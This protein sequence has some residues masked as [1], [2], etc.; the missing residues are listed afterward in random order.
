MQVKSSNLLRRRNVFAQGFI[1]SCPVGLPVTFLVSWGQ[2]CSEMQWNIP[3]VSKIG[4]TRLCDT[5]WQLF[6]SHFQEAGFPWHFAPPTLPVLQSPLKYSNSLAA[7]RVR[8]RTRDL[9]QPSRGP[10]SPEHRFGP[11]S[12][13]VT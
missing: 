2:G 12:K 10:S 13:H 3:H 5:G 11:R 7:R 4:H 8:G 6:S 1:N 9:G